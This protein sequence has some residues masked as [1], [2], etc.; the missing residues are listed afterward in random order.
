MKIDFEKTLSEVLPYG[1]YY[2]LNKSSFNTIAIK[3][4]FEYLN[5]IKLEIHK[6]NKQFIDEI[7]NTN[8]IE[9]PNKLNALFKDF[10]LRTKSNNL[11]IDKWLFNTE[12]LFTQNANKLKPEQINAFDL[13]IESLIN[14]D[15]QV[16][17]SI[18]SSDLIGRRF[19]DNSPNTQ[20][21]VTSHIENVL[22]RYNLTIDEAIKILL[23]TIGNY[24]NDWNKNVI[25]EILKN[26]KERKDID[27]QP[28]QVNNVSLNTDKNESKKPN[29]PYKRIFV[30]GYA[31][32][33]FEKLRDEI[34]NNEKH[35]YADYS[36]IMQKMINDNYLIET[37]HLKLIKFIDKNYN[38]E[39]G[40]KYIQFKYS[41]TLNKEK[42]YSRL[43]K[44]FKHKINNDL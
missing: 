38:T 32:E 34:L 4:K 25:P 18:I 5:V 30:N 33:F 17:N 22:Y 40:E 43:N 10:K 9:L 1:V 31:Y 6:N 12:K 7:I 24:S 16:R 3:T 35:I 37:N 2:G 39:I 11:F 13:W 8:S 14:R 26:L 15:L 20:S 27:L 28:Q 21:V 29:N 41:K 44:E 23:N 36:F 19:K 42:T